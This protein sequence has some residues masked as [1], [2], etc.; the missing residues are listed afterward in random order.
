RV[1]SGTTVA[2]SKVPTVDTLWKCFDTL[3]TTSVRG[4]SPASRPATA[5]VARR[6][7]SM[8]APRTTI[9]G[10][11]N[12]LEAFRVTDT[13]GTPPPQGV[14]LILLLL[15]FTGSRSFDL[16]CGSYSSS[17]KPGCQPRPR[18]PS[19]TALRPCRPSAWPGPCPPTRRPGQ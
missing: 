13:S 14:S 6:T 12:S 1:S 5:A 16:P 17:P 4:S 3:W 18:S 11:L 7:S 10:A 19:C 8:L 15:H 2:P 9:D